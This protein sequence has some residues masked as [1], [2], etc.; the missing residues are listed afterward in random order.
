MQGVFQIIPPM[1]WLVIAVLATSAWALVVRVLMKKEGDFL[2]SASITDVFSVIFLIL[3][4]VL[5]G[6]TFGSTLPSLDLGVI[7]PFQWVLWAGV[8]ILYTG[9]VF[10]TF[11]AS[12][13]VEAAERAILGQ[14]QIIWTVAFSAIFLSEPLGFGKLAAIF[15]ILVGSILCIYRPTKAKWKLEGVHL[16]L[17]A[18]LFIGG[19]SV[20]DKFNLQLIPPLVYAIP[21]Y[22]VPA[23]CFSIMMGKDS[24]SRMGAIAKKYSKEVALISFISISSFTTLLISLSQMEA[25]VAIP[26]LNTYIVVTALGGMLLLGEREAWAQKLIGALLAFAGAI[27]IA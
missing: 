26:L 5:L 14:S 15:L 6:P 1:A 8:S 4:V 16:V 22:A 10:F 23:I 7:P 3:F 12:Q 21:T 18:S 9:Y 17:I 20:A 19:A 25:S 13:K 27:M 11:K 2:A 24:I